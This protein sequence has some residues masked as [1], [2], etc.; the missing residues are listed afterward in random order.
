ML[1]TDF[2]TYE[3]GIAAQFDSCSKRFTKD[4][5]ALSKVEDKASENSYEILEIQKNKLEKKSHDNLLNELKSRY[6]L[7][8]D[9]KELYNKVIP[10]IER[11]EQDHI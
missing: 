3:N 9:L 1:K 4:E 2:Q 10:P 11:F 7:Y 8:D 5:L 6:C